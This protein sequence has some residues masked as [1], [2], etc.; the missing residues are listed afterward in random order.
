M[1]VDFKVSVPLD[2]LS[3]LRE[4]VFPGVNLVTIFH[5]RDVLCNNG[6]KVLLNG[7]VAVHV[8]AKF[9]NVTKDRSI[10]KG[11]DKNA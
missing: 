8:K 9:R 10:Y 5:L 4:V 1:F 6:V 2:E 11:Q 7:N 3:N